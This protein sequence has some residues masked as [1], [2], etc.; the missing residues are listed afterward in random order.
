MAARRSVESAGGSV[1]SVQPNLGMMVADVVCP[2]SLAGAPGIAAHTKDG[3]LR[4]QSLGEDAAPGVGS[5]ARVAD[6][7][8]AR[9]LWR[10][11]ITGKGVG[12]AVI[13]T[14]VA[15]HPTLDEKK[16]TFGPDLSVESQIPELRDFDTYGHGTHMAAVM[17]GRE[18]PERA[19]KEYDSDAE[20][21]F[22]GIAPDARILSLKVANHYGAADVSQVIAAIDWVVQY[23]YTLGMNIRV[24][25][26]S[27]GTPSEQDPLLDP[28]AYAADVAM[29]HGITVVC[30]AGNDRTGQ[31]GLINPAYHAN[32]LAV[33]AAGL[34]KGAP[35]NAYHDMSNWEVASF[36]SVQG[37]EAAPDRAP[38]VVAPGVS[39]ISA[40]VPGSNVALANPQAAVGEWGIRGSGTSQAAAVVSGAAALLL[41]DRPGLQPPQLRQLLYDSAHTLWD[42]DLGAQGGGMV[43]LVSAVDGQYPSYPTQVSSKGTGTLEDARGGVHL[44]INNEAL[45]GEQDIMGNEWDSV[46]MRSLTQG[47]A[48]WRN[49]SDGAAWNSS[50]WA[51]TSWATTMDEVWEGRRWM[52]RR[53]MDAEWTS[54]SWAGVPWTDASWASKQWT[55]AGWTG[56]GWGTEIDLMGLT[57]DLWSTAH[58]K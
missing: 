54:E 2:G 5:L 37:G 43:D 24:I 20:Q 38:D 7:I 8:G 21:Y 55:D 14:G 39:I 17:A 28:L 18:G 12:I 50:V 25:N 46:R 6:V 19:G 30:A 3:A 48:T 13:D 31:R 4:P 35:T 58:W 49:S 29:L 11:G 9:E 42:Q 22:Y 45:I 15:P 16:L 34:K 53:W 33:G 10:R 36:S 26:L 57:T 51:A 1:R 41:Q 47:L 23:Q 32:V 52:G 56:G 44:V 40:R 27:Y